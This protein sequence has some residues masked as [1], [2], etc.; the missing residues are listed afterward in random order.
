MAF[1]MKGFG[2]P[3]KTDDT[4]N[5]TKGAAAM[6]NQSLAMAYKAPIKQVAKDKKEVAGR[7]TRYAYNEAG[8]QIGI[9][10]E[11]GG[12]YQPTRSRH[13]AASKGT[14]EYYTEGKLDIKDYS[15]KIVEGE[16]GVIRG[17]KTASGEYTS[18]VNPTTREKLTKKQ[19]QQLA[20][21]EKERD[22]FN[23]RQE[24]KRKAMRTLEGYTGPYSNK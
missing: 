12:V 9:V 7:D 23:A 4:N 19:K 1:K 22:I 21:F 11:G 24:Q 20:S 18:F 6:M 8:E 16:G 15:G 5:M 14:G 13:E 10:G 17:F 3:K 2:Q